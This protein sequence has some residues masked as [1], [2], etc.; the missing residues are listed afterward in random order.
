MAQAS[1][2]LPDAP[3]PTTQGSWA[4]SRPTAPCV[5]PP[6]AITW[7]NCSVGSSVSPRQG[8][9]GGWGCCLVRR[10]AWAGVGAQDVV[11]EWAGTRNTW[12]LGKA[13]PP[14]LVSPPP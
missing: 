1:R 5:S 6:L 12:D 3:S 4:S 9:Q 2:N 11:V 10:W 13:P 14:A 7:R 8:A